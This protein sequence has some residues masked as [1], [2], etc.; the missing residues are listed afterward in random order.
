MKLADIF[1]MAFTAIARNTV[2]SIL[3]A[4]GIV[5][6]VGSVIAMVHLGQAATQSVQED[7]ASMGVNRL[8]VWPS[9]GVRGPGGVFQR[10]P[11]FTLEDVEAL[12]E[13]LQGLKVAPTTNTTQTLIRGNVNHDVSVTGTS[14]EYFY[15]FNWQLDRGR[16]F[17]DEEEE[18]SQTVCVIG[19]TVVRNMFGRADPMG[20]TLRVGRSFCTVVGI[21]EGKGS[22]PRGD[23]QDDLVVMPLGAVQSR[24]LGSTNVS[25][26]QISVLDRPTSQAS[27]E[28]RGLLRDRRGDSGPQDSFNLFDSQELAATLEG[29][30]RTLTYLLA[31]IALIS[32]LVGGIGIMNIMLVSVT[33]RTREI[34]IRIAIGARARDVMIQF[35]V[36]SIAISC[37]GGLLGVGL[38]VVGTYFATDAMNLPFVLSPE[39]MVVAFGFSAVVGVIFG[40]FPARKAAN[41]NPIE[42]LRH[43]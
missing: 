7:I 24:L 15:V 20:E 23:D 29:T 14:N 43:E 36:E 42:A 32:L 41:L 40:F 39:T 16:F 1:T 22:S 6:G 17:E 11:P 33:E 21:L 38:G 26:I 28:I 19:Q 5:I 30:T 31:A 13:E 25:S 2:R 18:F 34:G 9:R 3:T 12:R 37:L 4:L 27:E 8:T 10:S 35:L